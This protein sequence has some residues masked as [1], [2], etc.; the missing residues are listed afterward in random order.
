MPV[1]GSH[2]KSQIEIT[3]TFEQIGKFCFVKRIR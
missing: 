1:Q 2:K 3:S